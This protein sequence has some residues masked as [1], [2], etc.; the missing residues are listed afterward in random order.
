MGAVGAS[1]HRTDADF[2]PRDVGADE[3]RVGALV[4]LGRL[5]ESI[6]A[7]TESTRLVVGR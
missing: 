5:L 6:M 7:I 4:H 1:A 3:R 2:F